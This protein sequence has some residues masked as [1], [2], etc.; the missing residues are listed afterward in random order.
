MTAPAISI[1]CDGQDAA[2]I[3]PPVISALAL[4]SGSRRMRAIVLGTS[5]SFLI[6]NIKII[7]NILDCY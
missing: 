2:G 7:M 6:V 1:H 4:L 5:S 3:S